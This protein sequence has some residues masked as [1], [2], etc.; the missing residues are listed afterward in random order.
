[1]AEVDVPVILQRKAALVAVRADGIHAG[2]ALAKVGVH[3]RSED[4]P[5]HSTL[6]LAKSQACLCIPSGLDR[7][8]K[9][10]FRPRAQRHKRAMLSAQGGLFL[11]TPRQ[12]L[13]TCWVT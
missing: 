10:A 4:L 7:W 9:R 11:R 5:Q 2:Q 1:M 6:T 8:I 12:N 3:G 13:H